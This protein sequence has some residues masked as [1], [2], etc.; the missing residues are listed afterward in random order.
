[1]VKYYQPGGDSQ[2]KRHGK[3]VNAELDRIGALA[4]NTVF[5]DTERELLGIAGDNP[6]ADFTW[7]EWLNL[8][9]TEENKISRALINC[10]VYCVYLEDT[11][12]GCTSNITG[13]HF[14]LKATRGGLNMGLYPPHDPTTVTPPSWAGNAIGP[15]ASSQLY[16]TAGSKYS[17]GVCNWQGW[18]DCNNNSSL[19]YYLSGFKMTDAGAFADADP[20]YMA[21]R[22]GLMAYQKGV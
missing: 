18:V 10:H 7:R 14:P 21:L 19:Q 9:L 16:R 11:I 4:E 22:I 13:V 1:L 15:R 3:I 17:T 2:S 8:P 12:S 5:L 6:S 20:Y